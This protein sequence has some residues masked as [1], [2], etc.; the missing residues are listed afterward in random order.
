MS[1][2]PFDPAASA[3]LLLHAWRD[4][5]L[6]DGLPAALR[7]ATLQQGYDVQDC[8]FEAAGGKRVGW[9]LGVGSP[10]ALRAGQ[11]SRPLIGQ[12]ESARCHASGARLHVA[13]Q[14]P[15]TIECEIAF[16]LARTLT[17]QVNR[18]VQPGDIRHTCLTF[19]VVRSRF[20]DRKR[21][22]WP[23]FTADNVGFEALVIGA[24]VCAGLDLHVLQHL[25][26][27]TRVQLDGQPRAAVL[28]G[29]AASDP[30]QAL[31]AL[32][33]H[34]AERGETLHA[35]DIVSTGA[36]CEP[37]DISGTG[38]HLSVHGLGCELR[39]LL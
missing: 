9:K 11:L 18:R 6:L 35:G 5:T 28:H 1:A 3:A 14:A 16:V 15:L 26:Q 30:L 37:F 12:L 2:T 34:A 4:G 8:L 24:P 32:Y 39:C 36:L 21:V 7:P 17:P 19:E 27:N 23:S 20:I 29:D 25:A 38:H 13:T 31:A 10:A 22:G 33:A